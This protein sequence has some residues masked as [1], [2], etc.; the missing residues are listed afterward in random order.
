MAA[1][2][3][4]HNNISKQIQNYEMDVKHAIE[5]N[6]D[7]SDYNVDDD[8]NIGSYVDEQYLDLIEASKQYKGIITSISPQFG[9][10]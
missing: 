10:A 5:N 8:V 1:C 3:W 6:M 2:Q 7:D 4:L 9:A